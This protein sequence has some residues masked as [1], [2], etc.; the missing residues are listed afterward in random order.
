M[1]YR[2]TISVQAEADLRGIYEYIAFKLRS[3][4]NAA[5]QLERLEKAINGLDMMSE[6]YALCGVGRWAERGFRK[7]P[8][9]NY[10]VFYIPDNEARTIHVLRVMYGGMDVKRELESNT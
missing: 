7:M 4:I 10:L 5:G 3:T 1:T 6:R 9:D 2:V 8:V